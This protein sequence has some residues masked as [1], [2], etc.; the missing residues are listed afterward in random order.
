MSAII[1]KDWIGGFSGWQIVT[2]RGPFSLEENRTLIRRFSAAVLVTKD[3][4][5]AGGFSAKEQA[6]RLESCQLIVVGRPSPE[7][8][9]TFDNTAA[10]V[11]AA[12]GT[13]SNQ[14]I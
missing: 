10:L 13:L 3:S 11:S 14:I 9:L 12:L 4:G 2:G 5:E 1:L 7:A 6:A 8:G